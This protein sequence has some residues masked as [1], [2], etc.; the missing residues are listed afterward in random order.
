MEL[1][2]DVPKIWN[3]AAFEEGQDLGTSMLSI[4]DAKLRLWAAIFDRPYCAAK[5]QPSNSL[6]ISVMMEAYLFVAQ[7]RPP[8]NIHAGQKLHLSGRA[9]RMD[10]ALIVTTRVTKKEE[11][12]GRKWLTFESRIVSGGDALLTGEILTI[13]AE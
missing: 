5:R 1:R 10:E 12:K 6:L 3:Y 8:G 4:D 2:S 11:R 9:P 7:P 13:W